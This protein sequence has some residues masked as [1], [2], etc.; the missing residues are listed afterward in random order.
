MSVATAD[1]K[2]IESTWTAF[3][4]VV[5]LR[6]VRTLADYARMVALMNQLLDAVGDD[7]T[8]RL[9]PLLEIVGNLVAAYDAA[10]LA[11]EASDPAAVLRFLMEQY[12][13]NQSD[14]ADI[15][16][17]PNLSAILNGRRAISR[18]VAKKLAARFSVGIEVFL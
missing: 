13:L 2:T 15:V 12:R 8:H 6:P 11:I 10:H 14:L 16:A 3:D 4:S 9:A 1:L 7:E 18:A 5:R 17:Q